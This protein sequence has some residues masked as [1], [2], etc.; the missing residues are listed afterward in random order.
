MEA[1]SGFHAGV[2]IDWNC[3]DVARCT[4]WEVVV[5]VVALILTKGMFYFGFFFAGAESDSL[6]RMAGVMV[7]KLKLKAYP[8]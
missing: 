6:W 2:E 8:L 3:S 5:I 4:S 7:H 1:A